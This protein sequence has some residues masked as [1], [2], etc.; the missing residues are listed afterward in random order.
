MA[1]VIKPPFVTQVLYVHQNAKESNLRHRGFLK[2]LF[3]FK[4]KLTGKGCC[5]LCSYCALGFQTAAVTAAADAQWVKVSGMLRLKSQML[6]L[7][8]RFLT[9]FPPN[10]CKIGTTAVPNHYLEI[11]GMEST[12]YLQE[13]I[14]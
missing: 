11:Q 2:E 3:T 13:M 12:H 6:C 10:V 1:V 9:L 5:S 8:M 7:T 4:L 14:K